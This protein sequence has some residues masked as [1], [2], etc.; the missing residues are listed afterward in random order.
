MA[1]HYYTNIF[2]D[3]LGNLVISG[4]CTVYLANSTTLASI[5]TSSS[6]GISRNSVYTDS[7]G[8][9]ELY[10]DDTEYESNQ[11]FKYIL[12]KKLVT[13]QIYNNVQMLG[14]AITGSSAM[15]LDM[16]D[17][18]ILNTGNITT[19]NIL[20]TTVAKTDDYT[21]TALDRTILCDAS[22]GS[23]KIT[24]SQSSTV[25]G[26][27]FEFK[28]TDSSKNTVTLEGYSSDN[29]TYELID[30]GNTLA[31]STQYECVSITNDG[32]NWHII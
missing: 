29:I 7:D 15:D 3:D 22:T 16:N 23:F 24:L 19:E 25:S 6:G 11:L 13:P 12:T 20:M 2:R 28:K 27:T 18:D 4:K 30:G 1:R 10:I 17:Y 21:T 26:I 31:I 9:F 14:L 32:S 8:K 5:Y